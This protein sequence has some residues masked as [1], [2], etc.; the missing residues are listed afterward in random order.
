MATAQKHRERSRYSYH[1]KPDFSRFHRV[2][3]TKSV[4]KARGSFVDA[5]LGMFK[6]Q[7]KGDK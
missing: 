7:K 1:N 2:A 3:A 6:R 4:V 5:L